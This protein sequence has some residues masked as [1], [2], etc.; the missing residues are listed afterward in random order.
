MLPEQNAYLLAWI[1][2]VTAAGFKG[3]VYCSGIASPDGPG[4]YIVTANDIRD[5]AG[6]RRITFFIYEDACPPSPGCVSANPP[7]PAASGLAYAA[8][9]QFAQSPRR[10]QYTSVCRNTYAKDENCYPGVG[11]AGSIF[12]DLDSAL[13]PDPS[14][15]RR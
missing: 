1:D 7:P 2:A 3:G 4:K 14:N 12:L 10:Q 8:V 5:H 6:S 15:G 13:S 11:S 9:W